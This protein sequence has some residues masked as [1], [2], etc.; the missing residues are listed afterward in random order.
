MTGVTRGNVRS[1]PS[2]RDGVA[3][4]GAADRERDELIA[5]VPAAALSHGFAYLST[6]RVGDA[7][8]LRLCTI[9]PRT[10]RK[11]VDRT[12]DLVSTLAAE[13]R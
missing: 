4:P 11:G 2:D 8:V 1:L 13:L 6:T 7:S 10:T 5:R 9:N 12:I 3:A